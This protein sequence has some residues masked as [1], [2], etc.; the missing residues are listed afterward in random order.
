M[1]RAEI[2]LLDQSDAEDSDPGLKVAAK[3]TSKA[4]KTSE[5]TSESCLHNKQSYLD[6]SVITTEYAAPTIAI[7]SDLEAEAPKKLGKLTLPFIELHIHFQSESISLILR[8]SQSKP[9]QNKRGRL[10]SRP[11]RSL[12]RHFFSLTCSTSLIHPSSSSSRRKVLPAWY[13]CQT[14]C[15]DR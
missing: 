6:R 15:S 8:R 11:R 10:R 12:V 14:T 1:P 5:K 2:V 9:R 13:S 7:D 4:L 3:S